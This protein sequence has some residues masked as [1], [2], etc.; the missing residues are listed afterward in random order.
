MTVQDDPYVRLPYRMVED[1]IWDDDELLAWWARLKVIADGMHPAP[2]PLPRRISDAAMAR[3]VEAGHI[4]LV[5]TDSFYMRSVDEDRAARSAAARKAAEARWAAAKKAPDADAL[6]THPSGNAPASD[7]TDGHEA[8]APEPHQA[9]DAHASGDDADAL[10][11]HPT[12][13]QAPDASPLR[14]SPSESSVAGPP[15]RPRGGGPARLSDLVP[16]PPGH[17]MGNG[18]SRKPADD[19]LVDQHLRLLADPKCP[20]E[21]RRMAEDQLRVMGHADLIPV[22]SA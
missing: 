15:A 6:R 22:G 13:H 8:N 3:L 12:A 11:A 18:H 10:R 9:V 17:P 20:A 4:K 19:E 1:A 14:S 16:R 21:L 7:P 5:G 2:A